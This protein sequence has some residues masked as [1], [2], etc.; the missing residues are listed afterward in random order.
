ML[1]IYIY[2]YIII[3]LYLTTKRLNILYNSE[4]DRGFIGIESTIA[5][6]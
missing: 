1:Y 2:M 5:E 4:T 6:I 3:S